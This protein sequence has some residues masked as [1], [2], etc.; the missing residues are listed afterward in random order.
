MVISATSPKLKFN[1]T[2]PR[3]KKELKDIKDLQTRKRAL[4]L[5]LNKKKII[6]QIDTWPDAIKHK[7]LNPH[8]VEGKKTPKG[9]DLWSIKLARKERML[10]Y[11]QGQEVVAWSI[12]PD[13]DS[14]Y[15]R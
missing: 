13:H 6:D 8:R 5:L 9:D 14:A 15:R 12:H 10:V 7:G 1:F 11:V 3:F 2:S 4:K